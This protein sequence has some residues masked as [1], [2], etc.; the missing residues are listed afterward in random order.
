MAKEPSAATLRVS[1]E[2]RDLLRMAAEKEHRSMANMVEVLILRY[3]EANGISV[4][5]KRQTGKAK[6]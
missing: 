3:C 4:D 2:V 1:D 6:T 5:R